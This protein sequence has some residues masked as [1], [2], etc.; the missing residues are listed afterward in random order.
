MHDS[1]IEIYKASSGETE[2]SVRLENETVWL[3]LNQLSELFQRDESVISR[4]IN[5]IYK[6]KELLR[7]AT[8]AKYA[9]VQTE[10]NRK[11]E[12]NIEHF[13]LDVIISVGYRIKSKRGTQF[14][15]WAN[16]I[17]KEYL[18]KGFS[19]NEKK[20]I[21][22]NE[23]LKELQGSVKILGE[24][25]D[26]KEL[27]SDE[28][29]GL[30]KLISDYSYALDILD[31]YDYQSLEIDQTSGKETYQLKYKEAIEQI[32]I[33]REAYGNSVLFGKEKDK[34]FRSSISTIYQTFEG[35]DLYPSIEEK[36]ANLLFF[37]TKNHS[38]TD[39][40]K[41][42]AAFLFLYFLQKNR[43]LFDEFGRK[44]IA[45]NALVALTLMIAVS[46]PEEKETIIKVIVNLINKRNYAR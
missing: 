23:R 29:I 39:G 17:I 44:R 26:Y 13:N 32:R 2:I 33:A 40:N 16:K 7:K 11:I 42:I 5:N 45:D 41:R 30:L 38:F 18:V 37:I 27:S 43:I 34:S 12:R 1:N 31:Q 20:L 19:I 9:T 22:Q 4:H 14:R 6:E 25:L 10:G 36:A 24:V 35:K 3:S 15:I 8:V 28:S 46:K 21:Q